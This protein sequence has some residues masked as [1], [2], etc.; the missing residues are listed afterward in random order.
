VDSIFIG[1]PEKFR[2]TVLDRV[3]QDEE[4][5]APINQFGHA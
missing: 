3:E 1:T 2:E 5:Q 4:K